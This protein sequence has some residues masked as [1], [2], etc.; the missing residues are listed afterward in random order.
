MENRL[1]L[2]SIIALNYNQ[3]DYLVE[4]L[5]AIADQTYKNFE[6][7]IT[8]DCSKDD[9]RE[10]IDKWVLKHPDLKIT[11]LYNESNLG[12]CKT[13]NKAVLASKGEF[14]KPIACDDVLHREYLEKIVQLFSVKQDVSLVCT[15]MKL[16]DVDS[17]VKHESNWKYSGVVLNEK[18]INDFQEYFNGPFLNTPSLAFKRSLFDAIGGYDEN[19][20]F[21][22]WDF[23]LR[24]KR[25]AEFA[26]IEESLVNYRLHDSNMHKNVG[27]LARYSE[28]IIHLL[29]K[30]LGVSESSDLKIKASICNEISNL[31]IIDE[32]KGISIWSQLYSRIKMQDVALPLLSVLTSTY[33]TEAYISNSLQA[34]LMQTYPN[35]QLVIVTD[36][37]TDKT[38]DI[39]K[40]YAGIHKNIILIENKAH[41][42]IISS[43]NI[44]SDNCTGD[45][46][47][48]MDLDDLMH[49][50]RFEKQMKFLFENSDTDVVSAWMKIFDE[51]KNVRNVTY[52]SDFETNKAS[53]LFYSPVSHAASVFRAEALKKTRYIEDYKYAEDYDLWFRIMKSYKIAVFPEYLYFYRTHSNQVT[54]EKNIL[55]VK[56]SLRKIG[57]NILDETGLSYTP[58]ELEF[59]TEYLMLSKEIET[60]EQFMQFDEWL[61]RILMANNKSNFFQEHKLRDFVFTNYWQGLYLKFRKELGYSQL[62]K[63]MS[64]KFNLYGTREKTKD[65]IKKTINK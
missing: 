31:L 35:I 21:E 20:V 30:H 14:I 57:A 1:S 25:I 41:L 7:I 3:S 65:I 27:R 64:S 47:A 19:L 9:S 44:A 5:D 18:K 43:F 29:Q 16:M 45:F 32:Q 23:I 4:S 50:Q 38:I 46:I 58:A 8:D 40:S 28:D 36:P 12:L 26:Y 24:A 53:M 62:A 49:P 22:D 13:L 63:V 39:I 61:N 55:I 6:I 60:P 52:R 33:N 51:K 10:K 54:N 48:R 56:E 17:V 15:D 11:R 37:C 59:H 42:V 34:I 2:I